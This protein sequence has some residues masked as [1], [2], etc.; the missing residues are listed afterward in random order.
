MVGLAKKSEK[1]YGFE[2]GVLVH[3]S[4]DSLG[5]SCQRVVVPKVR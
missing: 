5:D 2:Q 1:G 4:V 3:C